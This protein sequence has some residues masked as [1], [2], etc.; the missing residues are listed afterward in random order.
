M[1]ESLTETPVAPV[2]KRRGPNKKKRNARAAPKQTKDVN[3]PVKDGEFAGVS[4]TNCCAACTPERCVISTV[5]VCKHPFKT[6]DSGCGPVTMKNRLRV[7]KLLKHQM[8]DLA[9]G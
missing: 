5:D 8:I 3:E 1:N 7:R 9:G 4:A 2:P 6:A